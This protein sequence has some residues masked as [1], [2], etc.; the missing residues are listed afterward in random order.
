MSL[1]KFLTSKTFF[2]NLGIAVVIVIVAALSVLK[3][4]EIITQHDVV[5]KVPNLINISSEKATNMLEDM[6][7]ELVVLDT[8]PYNNTIKPYAIVEQDPLPN[9]KVK[10]GR[11]VYVQINAGDYDMINFPDIKEGTSLRQAE[12]ILRAANLVVGEITYKKHEYK[13]VVLGL[14]YK[15]RPILAGEKVKQHS[16]VDLVLGDGFTKP[17]A[18][19]ETLNNNQNLISAPEF[20]EVE[21]YVEE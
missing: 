20:E 11:K 16:K 7:L 8:I 9:E 14:I 6:D 1:L 18:I 12:N 3:F 2:I 17:N 10:N 19:D 5:I 21:G 4:L 15:G 13:D